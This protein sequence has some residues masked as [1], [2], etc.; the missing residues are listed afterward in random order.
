MTQ[1]QKYMDTISIQ[2][3]GPLAYNGSYS[4]IVNA[5]IE[6]QWQFNQ[7]QIYF[8]IKTGCWHSIL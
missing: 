3:L 4:W 6:I 8:I 2:H 5:A 1:Q 7:M